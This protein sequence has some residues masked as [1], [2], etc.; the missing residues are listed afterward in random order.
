MNL[1]PVGQQWIDDDGQFFN[2]KLAQ[3]DIKKLT[4]QVGEV[5]QFAEANMLKQ[6]QYTMKRREK[7]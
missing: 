3:E 1:E 7:A 5:Q 2:Y 6:Q 4:R